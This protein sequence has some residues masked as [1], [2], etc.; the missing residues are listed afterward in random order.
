[1]GLP[2]VKKFLCCCTLETGGLIIGWFNIILS[3]LA[4]FGIITALSLTVVAFNHGDFN[5]N[6]NIVGGFAGKV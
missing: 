3:F 4:L 2:T 1:M 5:D 6:P